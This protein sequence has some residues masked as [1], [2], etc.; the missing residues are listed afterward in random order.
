MKEQSYWKNHYV[1][2]T[3]ASEVERNIRVTDFNSAD[4]NFELVYFEKSKN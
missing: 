2:E 4:K 1:L 3:D